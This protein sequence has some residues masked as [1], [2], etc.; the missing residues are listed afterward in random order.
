MSDK[1]EKLSVLS[2]TQ[3][4]AA[5]GFSM[6]A[7]SIGNAAAYTSP[8]LPSMKNKNVTSFSV[9]AQEASWVGGIM[10]LAGLLGGI[11]GGPL[12]M[13]VGRKTTAMLSFIPF[14]IGWTL[15]AFASSVAMLLVGRG[16]SGFAVGV[17]SLALPVYLSEAIH[18]LIR[19]ILGLM[20]TLIGNFG[21]L[22]C[23][24]IGYFA[25]WSL[26]AIISG[27]LCIPFLVLL[28]FVPES[29]R[30]YLTRGKPEKAESAL[31]RLRRKNNNVADEFKEMTKRLADEA[32]GSNT[33]KD[34]FQKKYFKP[35]SIAVALMIF[36]QLSGIS[37]VIFYTVMIFNMSDS[38]VDSYLSTI[39]VGTVNFL[40]SLLAI[41][42]ID[43]SGRKV[44]LITS[45]L[46]MIITLFVLSAFFYCKSREM[47][48]DGGGWV[49][50]VCLVIYVLGFSMGFGPI[51]WLMMGEIL[52]SRI[53]APAASLVVGCNWA[54]TFIVTKTFQDLID[55]V[56]AH[57]AFAFF[58]AVCIIALVFVIFIVP[59]TKNKSL[60]QIEEELT[61]GSGK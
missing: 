32:E 23:F 26:L 20:P 53:R 13:Y 12:I 5:F 42:N 51:P 46:S 56:G 7:F 57:G 35:V 25:N 50:L 10:P 33:C 41:F 31:A 37:A 21:M 40:A 30:W 45:A 55:L 19:G 54:F 2:L 9:S 6:C 17:A 39:I 58:C 47:N 36:Q 18:P 28:F 24:I 27:L 22:S 4:I 43:H 29:P 60:E 34:I 52:P 44:L 49:P 59:E 61:G 16:L 14:F 38:S 8:A 48:I 1:S 11:L 3:I 15:I